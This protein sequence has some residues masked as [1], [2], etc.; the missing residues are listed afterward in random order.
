MAERER[1]AGG[2][3]GERALDDPGVRE[4]PNVAHRERNLAT[5]AAARQDGGRPVDASGGSSPRPRGARQ[6]VKYTPPF[7]WI[8]C[9]V[10]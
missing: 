6:D 1:G 7:T 8:V 4:E 2:E 3:D 9:P 10:T 5:G